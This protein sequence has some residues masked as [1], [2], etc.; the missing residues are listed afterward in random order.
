MTR[1]PDTTALTRPIEVEDW[2]F[3]SSG[4]PFDWLPPGTW[5]RLFVLGDRLRERLD[6]EFPESPA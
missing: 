3:L 1:R 6:A 5:E 4:K 2:L